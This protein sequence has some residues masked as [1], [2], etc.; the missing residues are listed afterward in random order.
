VREAVAPAVPP[1]R[2]WRLISDEQVSLL[3]LGRAIFSR[4]PKKGVIIILD[5]VQWSARLL[6]IVSPCLL[7]NGTSALLRL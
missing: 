5:I 1:P 4:G 7:L 3:E 6:W 2:G